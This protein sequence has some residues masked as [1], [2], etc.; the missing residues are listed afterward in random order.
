MRNR[1]SIYFYSFSSLYSSFQSAQYSSIPPHPSKP[2]TP[3]HIK[4][5]GYFEL[6]ELEPRFASDDDTLLSDAVQ[7]KWVNLL[8]EASSEF[9]RPIPLYTEYKN[10]LIEAGFEDV[11]EK[12]FKLPSNTWPK[13]KGLK[14]IAKFQLT[15][16]LDGLEGLTLGLLTRVKGW[17]A[18]EV[19]AFL[20]QMEAEMK[21]RKIHSYQRV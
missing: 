4:P 13:D 8:C 14:Q 1:S 2:W 7:T 12:V 17:S 18:E 6:Q 15:S 9:G 3:R 20:E 19:K 21:D 10:C 16:Y 11:Q 5:G